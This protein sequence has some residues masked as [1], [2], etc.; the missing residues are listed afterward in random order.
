M[1]DSDII[2]D[3]IKIMSN[4]YLSNSYRHLIK[5]K[6]I[7][8]FVI[9]IEILLNTTQELN[10]FC[11][12]F[13]YDNEVKK[14]NIFNFTMI[15]NI[16]INKIPKIFRFFIMIL[17]VII[18][19]LLYLFLQKNNYIIKNKYI[20]IIVNILELLYF[21][22][23]MLIFFNLLFSFKNIYLS[24][25]ILLSIPH[26]YL[27]VSNFLYNHLY[28]FVPGF[29]DYPYDEFS[30][31]FDIIQF[32]CKIFLS[33][34]STSTHIKI[35]LLTFIILILIQIFFSF[36]FIHKLIHNSNLFMKNTF[37]NR[38]RLSLFLTQTLIV[39]FALIYGKK[40]MTSVLFIII[41]I[42]TLCIIMGYLYLIYNPFLFIQIK[43][44]TPLENIIFYLY[45]ISDRNEFGFLIKRKIRDHYDKCGMCN[46]C[47][48]YIYYF[49]KI[50]NNIQKENDEKQ[51]LLNEE[52]DVILDNK[53]LG[54]KELKD[55]FYII[56]ELK[57]KYFDF[58]NDITT[59]YKIKGRDSLNNNAHYYINLLFLIYSEYE[60]NNFT[61]LLNEKLILE[62]IKNENHIFFEND[63]SQIIQLLLSN[64]FI[65]LSKKIIN[66][67]K[68]ILNSESN[69]NKAKKLIELSLM[70]KEMKN[71]NYKHYLLN[72]KLDN[73]SNTKNLTSA[74][75]IIYE[76]IFNSI[77][78]NS[79]IPIR[80]N[81]QSLEEIFNNNKKDKII[82]LSV[83][84]NKKICNIIRAGKDLSSNLNNNL[85]N[86]FPLIFKKY[87]IDLFIS[88]IL[89]YFDNLNNE[90]IIIKNKDDDNVKLNNKN[91]KIKVVENKNNKDKRKFVE[92]KLIICENISSIIYYKLLT[93]KLTPLF[94]NDYKNFIL[95][96][97]LYFLHKKTIITMKDY[98]KNKNAN[99]KLLSIS[100]PELEKNNET[101]SLSL[102]NYTLWLNNQGYIISKLS[103]FE[104][105]YKSFIV[106][107]IIQKNKNVEKNQEKNSS[108]KES[109]K[110]KEDEIKSK[111]DSDNIS[112]K[113]KINFFDNNSSAHLSQDTSNSNN[114]GLSVLANRHN[115]KDT[116][117]EFNDLNKIKYI[118][119]I[120]IIIILVILLI[121]YIHLYSCKKKLEN[122]NDSFIKFRK[123]SKYYFQIFSITL[124][125]ACIGHNS[126]D[127]RNIIS[128]YS[129][130]YFES[131][132]KEDFNMTL[133][134]LIHSQRLSNKMI[135]K[136]GYTNEIHSLIGAKKYN[137]IFE[138][139]IN[140]FYVS[141]FFIENEI[142]FSIT[143]VEKKFSETL[144]IM[145][146]S[147]NAINSQNN[148][149]D[150]IYFL[151]KTDNPF[152][153]LNNKNSSKEL[154]DFQKLLY[155]MILNYKMY[156]NELGRIND[157]FQNLLEESSKLNKIYIYIYLNLDILMIL[158]I[159]VLIFFYIIFF[160]KSIVRILNFINMTINTKNDD[161][162]FDETF[163]KKLD[164]LEI[165]L[166]FYK[167]D[168]IK[169]IHDLNKLYYN[170]QQYTIK[171]N[172]KEVKE[173]N[174]KG[175]GKI[176]YD[177]NKKNNLYNIPKN[178]IIINKN[179]IR[180]LN[181]TKKY[182]N[183][184]YIVVLISIILYS[185]LLILWI[186]YFNKEKDLH[187]LVKKN[188]LL[189]T[190]SYIAMNLYHLIIFYNL[191]L[192]EISK[193]IYPDLYVPQESTNII[194]SFYKNLKLVF[195]TQKEKD[196]LG[197][198]Y[199]DEISLNFTC[200]NL[201]TSNKKM[202]KEIE[203]TS[204][205][206]QFSGLKKKL[207]KTC[208]N[209]GITELNDPK[210]EF[211]NHFQFI[212]NGIIS[213]SNYT[214]DGLINHIKIGN[215][216]KISLLFNNIL[217]YLL[218]VYITKS[219]K[220][221]INEVS[222][223]WI[224]YIKIMEL[225]FIFVDVIF[226][227]IIIF[228]LFSKIKNFCSQILLL[229]NVFKIYQIQ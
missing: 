217:I 104:I 74:C 59:N 81:I 184:F 109:K 129:D 80:D 155:E 228:F 213:I 113:D 170:Y 210:I 40:E 44:E 118:I 10:I 161:F 136:K 149:Y 188:T 76:E 101:Y 48:K 46:L 71:K 39:I 56:N 119:Y 200:D 86:L 88:S 79:L 154:T 223:T 125:I 143:T 14:I 190:S 58:I 47:K 55:L 103:S 178:Q 138:K 209:F 195:S 130:I 199:I 69:L 29:I 168:P 171:K 120:T 196:E 42:I 60:K 204:L 117:N 51:R 106:Y 93:L 84:L 153:H 187:L 20:S 208:E 19:D 179:Q 112:T 189:E 65:S 21:R 164:N 36:Y 132:P 123:F 67:F 83:D 63:K 124:S 202:I 121:E 1:S 32:I 49:N 203:E 4:H 145:C 3:F 33:S 158:F 147:F 157:S 108:L 126:S 37:L 177:K 146:N 70:L 107:M 28:Y 225:L 95:F 64:K 68:D 102:K 73:P 7:H 220:S 215:L 25:S 13:L 78:S 85:F 182:L 127:C 226:I 186:N 18:F 207:I 66:Q 139:T 183:V 198:L 137:Q 23:F 61:L 45:M 174:K 82:T 172:K 135:D 180:N 26:I 54:K 162:K 87:Q 91:T 24:I 165:I 167:N 96:D 27:I 166:H 97:G 197:E 31:S 141:Q 100:T 41:I 193:S 140:Y 90:K 152:E 114:K 151:N 201:Y 116:L 8:F 77:I 224:R 156:S 163:I 229:K 169:A 211:E 185:F 227:F 142:K 214:Y 43:R 122:Y 11:T 16:F 144:L 131:Y 17:F 111:N 175:F 6:T 5:S 150:I 115:K 94:N 133:L 181:I 192:S 216:G 191:T 148:I 134:F 105:S 92:I 194:K 9:L 205:G 38:T 89:N 50:E 34:C 219:D 22:I 30:S 218:E 206:P 99:E 159:A 75:S 72:N 62:I 222:S 53:Y 221:T 35:S 52:K 2:N 128:Y 98:R 173:I 57:N 110:I 12:D 212:K 160:E 15:I 176:Y